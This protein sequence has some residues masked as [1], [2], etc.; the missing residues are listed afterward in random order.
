MTQP[1]RTVMQ[2]AYVVEN[3]EQALE[4]WLQKIK[5]GPFFVLKSLA[6]EN[7]RYR[8]EPT[9]LDI[10]V[11]LG[12]SGNLCI[13]LIQQNCDSPSVYR[14]LLQRQGPGF[15]HWG[16]YS[17]TFDEDVLRYQQ[18][19]HELAFS[20][21]VSVGARF[22]YMDTVK[23]LGGMLE[24]IEVTP[25]VSDLFHNMESAHWDWDGRDPVRYVG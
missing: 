19:N 11:A 3:M 9:N 14:E 22:A 17:E 20:G 16:L 2:M 25:V 15:H 4:R 5:V 23:D 6:A 7:M 1:E 12:F 24:L 8:G 21:K 13:E 18:Q 10:D